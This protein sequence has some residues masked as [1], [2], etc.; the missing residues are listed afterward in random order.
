MDPQQ[1][2]SGKGLLAA[3]RTLSRAIFRAASEVH[4]S[5]DYIVERT[6]QADRMAAE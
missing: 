4:K 2:D 3:D 6:A 1:N 5:A